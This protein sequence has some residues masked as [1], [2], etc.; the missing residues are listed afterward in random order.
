LA[1]REWNLI[2]EIGRAVAD[3]SRIWTCSR[4]G[5]QKVFRQVAEE[6]GIKIEFSAPIRTVDIE[7]TTV[8]LRDGRKLKADLVVGADGECSF[9]QTN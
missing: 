6:R 8:I 4:Y 1:P 2:V 5:Y 9:V 7:N 3:K